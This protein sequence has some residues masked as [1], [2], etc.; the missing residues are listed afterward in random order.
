MQEQIDIYIN[1]RKR[2]YAYNYAMWVLEWDMETELPTGAVNHRAEQIEVLTNEIY[3][4][5]TDKKYLKAITELFENKD[6]LDDLL[7]R[8][9]EKV[10]KEMRLIKKMPKE[11]YIDYQVLLSKSTS[12]WSK[13]K[14]NDDFESFLPTL[15]KIVSYQRKIVKYLQTPTL[16]GYDV[17]LDMYEEGFTTKEYDEFFEKLRQEL[18]PFV[19][20]ATSGKKPLSRKLTKNTFPIYKQKMFNMYLTDVFKFDLARGALRTSAHPFTSNFS[21]YDVRITTRYLENSIESAIFSTIHEMGH[22][23]YEQNIN[24][25]LNGTY[26]ATGASM[27]IHESQSRMYENMIAR[28]YSFWE[29]HYDH[30]KE[31]F[32]K[33]L[34]GVSLLEFYQY[35]NR[36]ERSVVRTEADE[37]T[38]PLH[39]M[40]RYEIEKLLIS[41]KLKPKDLAKKWKRLSQE[42]IGIRPKNDTEGV[43]QDIHWAVGSFGY[44]PTYALGSA[45]AAQIYYAMNK[46]FNIEN[47]IS[48][49]NIEKINQ[50]LKQ[51]IHQYGQT[52]SPKEIIFDATKE[53]FNPNY[54]IEYL[55]RKFSN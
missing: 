16:K 35:I 26:L 19:L 55:K 45:Y 6:K 51:H 34:K 32:S 46:D 53:V 43:L 13:A 5:E 44:F 23:I 20:T 24:P 30:L 9:I 39:I 41:G 50:W 33:E 40:V 22:A 27:G 14:S 36:A 29:A 37:L 48:D 21:T 28:S 2:L 49:N 12:I 15:E 42:Y 54:Y 7:K 8:E 18:L 1:M 17:L 10:E 11:E 25:D 38:Y 4:L 52:K 31:I 47:A 3:A